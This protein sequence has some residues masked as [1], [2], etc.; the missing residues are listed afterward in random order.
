MVSG[1]STGALT[2]PYAFLGPQ[3]DSV[4]KAI[5]T[6][7]ATRDLYRRKNIFAIVGG[8]A[9]MDVS[10][11]A[12]LI[13]FYLPDRMIDEI[14]AQYRI[15][16]VLTIGTTNLDTER[17]VIWDIGA[18][19]VSDHPDKYDLVRKVILASASLPVAF[20]PVSFAVSVNRESFD[21]LHV[22]GGVSNQVFVYPPGTNWSLVAD[23][24]GVEG[25][26]RLYVIRNAQ[27]NPESKPV[28][29][30]VFQ[31]GTRSLNSLMRAQGLGDLYRIY[32]GTRRDRIDFNL[33]FIP[34]D[35]VDDSR[36][37][38]DKS[39]MLELYNLG[40]QL[41][42]AG[43]RWHKAPPGARAATIPEVFPF[44]QRLP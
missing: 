37:P 2:A 38:I 16:R 31:I 29:D 42:R 14:A 17:P 9:F 5:Y 19:A 40:E 21:E 15:G 23:K 22:D 44:Q 7:H 35:F 18:I 20:P 4:I 41:G 36:E 39:T 33:A 13:E 25:K 1:V 24:L 28:D 34:D 12:A 43:Y 30:K 32:M 11:F 3:Y 8:N 26:P 10:G 6:E 27:L